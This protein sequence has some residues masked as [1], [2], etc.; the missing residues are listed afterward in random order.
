MKIAK[1]IK[2]FELLE[3]LKI[4]VDKPGSSPQIIEGLLGIDFKKV[5]NLDDEQVIE[6]RNCNAFAVL[7]AHFYSIAC[8]KKLAKYAKIREKATD[9]MSGLGK[10][11]FSDQL[12]DIDLNFD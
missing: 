3:P 10:E 4:Q 2:S 12:G 9:P 1:L 7:F 5:D 6:L 11:I 8:F